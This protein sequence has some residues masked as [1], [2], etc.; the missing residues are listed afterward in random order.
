MR[1][2]KFRVW[3]RKEKNFIFFNAFYGLYSQCD[4]AYM[5]LNLCRIEQYTGLKDMN[6]N[7]IYEGDIITYDGENTIVSYF[8]F[9]IAGFTVNTKD[10]ST[11]VLSDYGCASCNCEIVGNIHD[12]K[13]VIL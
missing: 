3:D 7:D 2:I 6:G 12:K 8:C 11:H 1:E 5:N 13:D 10:G 9:Y 4:E